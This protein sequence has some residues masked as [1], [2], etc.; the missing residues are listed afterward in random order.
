M[1]CFTWVVQTVSFAFRT[2]YCGVRGYYGTGLRV[3]VGYGMTKA[4]EE[5]LL[6]DVYAMVKRVL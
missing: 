3:R 1:G 2:V 4:T 6:F 5:G